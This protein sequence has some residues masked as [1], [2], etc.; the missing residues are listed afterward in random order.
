MRNAK[1]IVIIGTNGTGKT[2][3]V[4]KL[5]ANELKKNKARVLIVTPDDIEFPTVP[6][7]HP[8]FPYRVG[9]YLGA[10]KII[11][12]DDTLE[13]IRRYFHDGLLIFDDCRAYLGAAL[14]QDLHAL[15]IRRRQ[16]AMDIIAVGHGFTEI[17]PKFF[18][19]AT[20]FIL[21]R[22]LDNIE[23]RKN[24]LRNYEAMKEAQARVNEKAKS[25]PHY[26]EV[27]SAL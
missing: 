24:V 26:Y 12:T 25:E 10:R 3:L 11:F 16:K 13:I 20:E 18:T 7:V 8:H 5:V 1:L 9:V 23:R 27:I 15:L 22:T 6:L 17:P 14:E 2:T 4:K 21:F 19:F